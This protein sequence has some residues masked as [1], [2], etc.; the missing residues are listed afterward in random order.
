MER[1]NYKI[2]LQ[3]IHKVFLILVSLKNQLIIYILFNTV[4]ISCT[5][6]SP[7]RYSNKAYTTLTAT[8]ETKI[9]KAKFE[10]RIVIK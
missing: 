10:N 9:I 3:K 2:M 6:G 7:K 1:L 5:T 4:R 8:K